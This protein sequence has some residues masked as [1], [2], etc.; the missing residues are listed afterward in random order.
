MGLSDSSAFYLTLA[1]AV[2]VR[3]CQQSKETVEFDENPESAKYYSESLAQLN[4]RLNDPVDRRSSGV[5]ATILGCICHDV[6]R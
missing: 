5:I 1:T 6:G 3:D 4:R 2:V